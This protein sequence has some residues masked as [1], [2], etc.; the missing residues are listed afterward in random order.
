MGLN[1][2]VQNYVER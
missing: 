2:Y 1:T